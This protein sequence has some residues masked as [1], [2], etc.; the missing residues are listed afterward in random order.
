MRWECGYRAFYSSSKEEL[1][2]GQL[3]KEK[4]SSENPPIPFQVGVCEI[5][6][7]A[8]LKKVESCFLWSCAPPPHRQPTPLKC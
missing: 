2:C 4:V 5:E 7:H 6:S 3:A 1:S 8:V